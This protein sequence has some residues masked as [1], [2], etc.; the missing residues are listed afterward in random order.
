MLY[1]QND[2]NIGCHP[3]ILD[4]MISGNNTPNP[5]YGAD[6][7]CKKAADLIR[8]ACEHRELDVHFLVGGTQTNLTVIAASLRPHQAVIAA[9]SAHIQVHET[10]AIENT[11]HKV[12]PLPSLD[13]KI[14]AEQ[15]DSY[16]TAHFLDETA[17][18]MAQPKMV[19]ISNPTELG[20][21]YSLEELRQIRRICDQKGLLLFLDGARLGYGLEANGNDVTL[22][23][24]AELCDVFY[25][26]GTKVGALFG[27]AVVIRN[28]AIA[29]DFRYLM[30]QHGAML[31]KGWLL[32][33]Q[34]VTLFQD[35]L[36]FEISK[37]ANLLADKLRNRIRAIGFSL[38]TQTTT[39][40]VFAVFPDA[41]LERLKE[42][43]LYS[44]QC[45]VDEDHSAV[46]FC[47]SWATKESDVESLCD[48]LTKLANECA[49]S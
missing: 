33:V 46:R 30:K 9:E 2:Y 43:V 1:F 37:H 15:I 5:G 17:E 8:A 36:Y 34:F 35:N 18:H 41:L 29:D 12:L 19:Y 13:G 3:K 25:I 39:N 44:Y 7:I 20:T 38:L 23:D 10:G 4:A 48:I 31:A 26:G 11:G 45:R 14:R 47:T 40:Q 24:L 6:E 16:V 32:G 49:C 27:E 22:K 21:I 42:S 28:A